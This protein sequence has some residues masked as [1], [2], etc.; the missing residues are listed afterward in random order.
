MDYEE[1][2]RKQLVGESLA[3]ARLTS[4]LTQTLNYIEDNPK[5]V[6]SVI[7]G[8]CQGIK[9]YLGGEDNTYTPSP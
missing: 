2:Y 6:H 5:V 8:I 4:F 7:V 1:L 3:S 9:H